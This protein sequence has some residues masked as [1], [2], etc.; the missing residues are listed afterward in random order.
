[1]RCE[2]AVCPSFFIIPAD[3]H[4]VIFCLVAGRQP[5]RKLPWFIQVGFAP[6]IVSSCDCVA[7]WQRFGCPTAKHIFYNVSVANQLPHSI[8]HVAQSGRVTRAIVKYNAIVTDCGRLQKRISFNLVPIWTRT[9]RF[10]HFGEEITEIW[11][12][13]DPFEWSVCNP[14]QSILAIWAVQFEVAIRVARFCDGFEQMLIYIY[15]YIYIYI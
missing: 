15:I 11:T 8:N 13:T 6:E 4:L 5:H 14:T 2:T 3:P 9:M 7:I 10:E 1:M 12:M